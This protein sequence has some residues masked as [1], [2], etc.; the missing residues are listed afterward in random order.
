LCLG[1]EYSLRFVAVGPLENARSWLLVPLAQQRSKRIVLP[2]QNGIA[3]VKLEART[4]IA[5]AVS[6]IQSARRLCTIVTTTV[7]F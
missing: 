3:L 6:Q 7:L 1:E 2:R 4:Q 5:R